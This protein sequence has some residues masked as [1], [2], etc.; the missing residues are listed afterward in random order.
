M[1]SQDA[2]SALIV[3]SLLTYLIAHRVL[4]ANLGRSLA[5]LPRGKV[6]VGEIPAVKI[7]LSA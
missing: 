2:R 6:L 4:G 5:S 7:N 3:C 1:N